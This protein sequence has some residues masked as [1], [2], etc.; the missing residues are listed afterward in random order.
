[1]R[2]MR[3]MRP[4]RALAAAAAVLAA[5]AGCSADEPEWPG[6]G[7]GPDGT[8]PT[9]GFADYAADVDETW[10][11]SPALVAAEFLRLDENQAPETAIESDAGPEGGGPAQVAVTLDRLLDDSVQTRRYDLQLSREGETW[12]LDRATWSQ[13]CRSGRGHQDLSPEPC[14]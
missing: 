10:E 7:L 12:R 11:R 14:L 4:M 3:P 13:I 2:P 1:M 9:E 8:I 6:P 5:L